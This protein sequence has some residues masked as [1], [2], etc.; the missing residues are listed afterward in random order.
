MF[1]N[2]EL[3]ISTNKNT[4]FKFQGIKNNYAKRDLVVN[5]KSIWS[6][7]CS[8]LF[9]ELDFVGIV[10]SGV[11]KNNDTYNEIHVSDR[12]MNIVSLLFR[13]NIKV[14]LFNKLFKNGIIYLIFFR[15]MVTMR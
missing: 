12:E 4:R 15:S 14:I 13:G 8:P 5:F 2:G 9:G 1:R 6:G 3:Q 10:V 11:I 7:T